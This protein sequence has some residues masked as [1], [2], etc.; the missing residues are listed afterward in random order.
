MGSLISNLNKHIAIDFTAI[1]KC[2][3]KQKK[4]LQIIRQTGDNCT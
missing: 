4:I 1:F 3:I 2:N